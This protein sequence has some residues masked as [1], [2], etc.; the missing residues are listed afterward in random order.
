MT[1]WQWHD[2]EMKEYNA[3]DTVV[4]SGKDLNRIIVLIRALM[5][6]KPDLNAQLIDFYCYLNELKP[7]KKSLD[8]IIWE[9]GLS[10]P[11]WDSLDWDEDL[12]GLN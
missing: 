5:D 6:L 8:E 4:L 10:C 11:S 1:S 3:N 2:F 7:M 9:A 12:K